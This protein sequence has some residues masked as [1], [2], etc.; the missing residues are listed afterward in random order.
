[1]LL[2][3]MRK[4]VSWQMGQQREALDDRALHVGKAVDAVV[5]VDVAVEVDV[6]VIVGV[7]VAAKVVVD[8]NVAIDWGL[9]MNVNIALHVFTHKPKLNSLKMQLIS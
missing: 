6:D 9:S 4:F 2:M 5:D 3:R 7:G 1:M 8:A